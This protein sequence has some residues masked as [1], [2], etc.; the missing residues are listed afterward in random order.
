MIHPF[1][2]IVAWSV[3]CLCV[4]DEIYNG[5]SLLLDCCMSWNG[6]MNR[7]RNVDC[8]YLS[9][10]VQVLLK[11]KLLKISLYWVLDTMILNGYMEDTFC[12]CVWLFLQLSED[13]L[14]W[15]QACRNSGENLRLLLSPHFGSIYSS[16]N[17]W[18]SS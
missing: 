17:A 3:F 16:Y 5:T 8:K 4:N 1:Y 7:K 11:W 9:D 14:Y 2:W 18:F 15:I 6:K 13:Q 10:I 12:N